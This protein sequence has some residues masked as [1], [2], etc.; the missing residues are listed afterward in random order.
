MNGQA[1]THSAERLLER[2]G[3]TGPPTDVEAIAAKL[4]FR[5]VYEQL[6]PEISGFLIN[7]PGAPVI[8]VNSD[9]PPPR[10]RLTIA[11]EIG[12]IQLRHTFEPGEFVHVDKRFELYR[13]LAASELPPREL[14]ACW[15]AGALL[16]PPGFLRQEVARVGRTPLNDEEIQDLARR[17]DV[18]VQGMTIR[19]S[20]LGLL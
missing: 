6:G 19:L 8:G 5:I 12:H 14:E 2:F 20:R 3:V 10:Q 7:K 4:G 11:H 15:F 9:Q 1:A 17:F 18:S 13:D 16:M